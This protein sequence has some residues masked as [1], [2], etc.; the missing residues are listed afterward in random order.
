MEMMSRIS[1]CIVALGVCMAVAGGASAGDWIAFNDMKDTGAGNDP[2]ATSINYR[3]SGE[4]KD[5]I[6]GLGVGVTATGTQN[7]P[8]DEHT[9]GGPFD[10]GTDGAVFNG[11]VSCVGSMELD[12]TDR[13]YL[14]TFRSGRG[15]GVHHHR[16][17]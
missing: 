16:D 17:V 1:T 12:T 5:I 6:T 2:N 9:N 10:A 3:S 14:M 13:Y 7:G 8:T 15:Q 11:V 4:L